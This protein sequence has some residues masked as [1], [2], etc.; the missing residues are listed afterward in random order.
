MQLTDVQI[1]CSGSFKG[2]Y[3]NV[4]WHLCHTSLTQL[5][6]NFNDNYDG[7]TPLCVYSVPSHT[8]NSNPWER[9]PF[10]TAFVYDGT[11]NLIVESRYKGY[12]S[13]TKSFM[14]AMW[15]ADKRS[16]DGGYSSTSG[17]Y[18]GNMPKYRFSYDATGA[19]VNPVA[20]NRYALLSSYP[21]PFRNSTSVRFTVS[22]SSD[23]R[24]GIY[25]L[26][27][28]LVRNLMRGRKEA[29]AHNVKWYGVN[30]GGRKV[31][32]GIYFVRLDASNSRLV[33]KVVFIR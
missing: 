28:I 5:S 29:G 22:Q 33:E 20:G 23:V 4:D 10:D 14:C 19:E 15:G 16:V 17:D 12:S 8:F 13:G 6:K 30:N 7:N 1:S 9:F 2:T 31:P 24:V 11:R 18:V 21:N 3:N 32:A 26:A 25:D 27:G